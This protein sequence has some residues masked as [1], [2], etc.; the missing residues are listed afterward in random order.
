MLFFLNEQKQEYYIGWVEKQQSK[1][2][3]EGFLESFMLQLMT[4][5]LVHVGV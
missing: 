2:R 3:F 4:V 5:Q 1:A